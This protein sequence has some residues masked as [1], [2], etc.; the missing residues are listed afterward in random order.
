MLR[1]A[2]D[3]GDGYYLLGYQPDAST[4]SKKSA[5]PNF[6]DINVRVKRPGL[7]VRSR[8]GFFGAPD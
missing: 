6:H 5:A 8:T 3:D 7:W 2:V 4:F 1:E